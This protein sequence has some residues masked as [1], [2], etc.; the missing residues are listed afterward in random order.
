MTDRREDVAAESS[1]RASVVTHRPLPTRM[2]YVA[3][4]SA[5]TRRRKLA[6]LHSRQTLITRVFD[7]SRRLVVPGMRDAG[8]RIARYR[9]RA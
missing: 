7:E 4:A 2:R 6:R 1:S 9:S 8:L 3:I 5:L